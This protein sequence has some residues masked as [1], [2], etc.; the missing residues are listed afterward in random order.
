MSEPGA[1]AR[2]SRRRGINWA[3]GTTALAALL[4]AVAAMTTAA[5]GIWR[6]PVPIPVPRVSVT[7][8]AASPAAAPASQQ[9]GA[10]ATP[11]R[12]APAASP[13]QSTSGAYQADWSSGM[14]GWVGVA[15]WKSI[16][17]ML[18]S[19]G[20]SHLSAGWA[21]RGADSVQPPRQPLTANYAVEARVQIV[22]PT[23]NGCYVDIQL[24]SQTEG[25]GQDRHG[26]ALG[27]QHGTGAFVGR[28]FPFA[29]FVSI[30]QTSFSPA[31][32]WHDY[33]AEVEQNQ[34]TLKIDGSTVLQATDNNYL[35]A[36]DVG[37]GNS[38]C[39]VQVSSF[40][41]TPL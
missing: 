1:R 40:T 22:D 6:P 31:G 16:P 14:N 29:N 18:V 26:Y 3:A 41:V 2:Q 15:Q 10:V 36:G 12:T 39:Q 4:S 19:D 35:D 33:R 30:K 27:Y 21:A 11:V 9:V 28:F 24:R 17:R 20:T 13:S 5:T 38:D 37:L 25:Q 34:L 23:E 8:V 32:D 7:W